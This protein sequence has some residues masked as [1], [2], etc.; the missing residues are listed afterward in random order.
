MISR[1]FK[2]FKQYYGY[3]VYA[4]K[5]QLKSEVA[6]SYLNW[7]WW[8]LDPIC[9]MII[10]AFIFGVVFNGKELYFPAF[11]FVG[12]SMWDFF[13]RCVKASVKMI[14][15][16]KSIVSKVYIPKFILVVIDM[17]VNG[18]KML[19][20]FVIVAGMMVVYRIPLHLTILWFI[21]IMFVFILFTFGCCLFLLHYGVYVEDLSNVVSIVLRI[22]FYMTGIFYNV[23]K[24]MPKPYGSYLSKCNPLAFLISSARNAL[25]Y[26]QG[27]SA[28]ILGILL[29]VS[30][31]LIC[32]GLRLVYKNENNYVKVI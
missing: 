14:R 11:I 1:F 26:G 28:L 32:L 3:I 9:F 19:I 22:I 24:R 27:S 12:L 29:L 16:N 7:L 20:S 30:L 15:N 23:E 4:A 5:S 2:D 21:P 17:I 10:Y 25:L 6:N 13:N 18:F 31:I 8:V